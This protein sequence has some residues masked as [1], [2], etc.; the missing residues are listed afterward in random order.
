MSMGAAGME[1][2]GGAVD[3]LPFPEFG[4]NGERCFT[5][6][7][8]GKVPTVGEAT[9]KP[10]DLP[11]GVGN[12]ADD[13]DCYRVQRLVGVPELYEEA[14]VGIAVLIEEHCVV[15]RG[16]CGADVRESLLA[17]SAFDVRC[18]GFLSL[19]NSSPIA[20]HLFLLK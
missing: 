16:E 10:H 7:N 18:R 6:A 3:Y 14:I 12:P 11:L 5:V 19:S 2:S 8:E 9:V 13:S 20:L 4:C 1:G 15:G 17:A